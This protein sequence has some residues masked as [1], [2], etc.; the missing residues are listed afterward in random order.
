MLPID[1]E[2]LKNVRNP[3]R[4]DSEAGLVRPMRTPNP[5]FKG[6]GPKL[7]TIALAL[8]GIVITRTPASADVKVI[9][10]TNCAAD[11]G[12]ELLSNPDAILPDFAYPNG[13]TTLR[14][15]LNASGRVDDVAIAQSSG[16]A[17]LDFAAMGV[18]RGSRYQ[19]ATQ[20][21]AAAADEFLYKVIFSD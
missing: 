3:G 20:S 9:A 11:H 21:C 13:E 6:W 7:L 2:D 8:C 10:I 19:P 14:V 16:D 12:A 4:P 5:L 1:H 18:V 17:M 15:K